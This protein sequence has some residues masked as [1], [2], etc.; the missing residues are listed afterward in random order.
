MA[1]SSVSPR[2]SIPSGIESIGMTF[3]IR[4]AARRYRCNSGCGRSRPYA[5]PWPVRT[6]C[7]HATLLR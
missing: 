2:R 1:L 7:A 4:A 6:L 3:L 5:R